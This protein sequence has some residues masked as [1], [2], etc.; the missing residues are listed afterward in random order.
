MT[1]PVLITA[2]D[3]LADGQAVFIDA[4]WFMPGAGQS[5]PER[6]IP[7]AVRLDIDAVADPTSGLPH[8]APGAAAFERWMSENGLDPAARFIVYDSNGWLA[9][10]RGWWTLR[11]FGL[12]ARLLDGGLAAWQAA[13]GAVQ[14]GPFARREP[15]PLPP[16]AVSLIRDDTVTW[17]DVLEHVAR[18]D[19]LIADARPPGRFAG[20]DPE[21]RPGLAS[22]HMPGAVSLPMGRL[23]EGGRFLRGEALAAALGETDRSKPV[24]CTCGSGVTA[25]VLVAG[26]T[27][28]GFTDVRLY[29]GSWT[30]WASQG[31]LPIAAGGP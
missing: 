24:I 5:E 9:S 3:A 25:A 14:A 29:D 1:N 12:D 20:T 31:D 7:G 28:A 27:M 11:R 30:E 8:M 19:A 2:E 16:G 17:R 26:F 18:G 22:G 4:T 21:P 13:G 23:I 10:A 15:T 6:H